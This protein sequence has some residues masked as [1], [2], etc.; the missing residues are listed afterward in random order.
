M[1]KFLA[2]LAILGNMFIVLSLLSGVQRGVRQGH[3]EQYPECYTET[4][5]GC[6]DEALMSSSNTLVNLFTIIVGLLDITVVNYLI[7]K[8]ITKS[9]SSELHK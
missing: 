5:E 7:W 3:M 2:V 4:L 9:D 1:K 6:S 8:A